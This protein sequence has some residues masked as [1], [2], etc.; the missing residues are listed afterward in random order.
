[1][2]D[3]H[4]MNE[5][6]ITLTTEK[7]ETFEVYVSWHKLGEATS[8][9]N[10]KSFIAKQKKVHPEKRYRVVKKSIVETMLFEE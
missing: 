6:S 2:G 10:A 7:P 4:R 5:K 3:L 9:E 8:E 1:M